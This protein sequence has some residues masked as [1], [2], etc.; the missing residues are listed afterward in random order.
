MA[1]DIGAIEAAKE[2]LDKR[3]SGELIKV[4]DLPDKGEM[5]IRIL[6]PTA[7]LGKFYYL[8]TVDLK[9]GK[10]GGWCKSLL[11]FGDA[12]CPVMKIWQEAKVSEDAEV[13]KRAKEIS[14]KPSFFVPILAL[15]TDNKGNVKEAK[16]GCCS[17]KA[18]VI[19]AISGF[20]ADGKYGNGT[21]H[22]LADRAKGRNFTIKRSGTTQFNTKYTVQ[23]WPSESSFED[24]QYDEAYNNTVDVVEVYRSM[25]GDIS[26]QVDMITNYL[27]GKPSNKPN[28][29]KVEDE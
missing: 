26:T 27:Y 25:M 29:G 7:S 13:A 14:E 18:T 2:E 3:G 19:S 4:S 9:L 5:D 6:P 17:A 15:E 21:E 23:P 20:F 8:K 16:M 24:A 1:L 11:T 10:D 12:N 28:K 22:L